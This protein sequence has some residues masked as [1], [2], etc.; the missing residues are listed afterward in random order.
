MKLLHLSDLHLGRLLYRYPLHEQQAEVLERLRQAVVSEKPDAVLIAGDVYDRGIPP[1]YATQLLDGFL[2]GL[3]KTETPVF[4]I[5]GNHDSAERL[6]FLAEPLR[7][8]GLYISPCYRG[9]V[10]PVT[11]E[12][13][14]GPVDIWLLPFLRPA[15]VRPFHPDEEI[16]TTDDAVACAI[17]HMEIDPARRNVLVAHQFVAGG[18]IS[19]SEEACELLGTQDIAVGGS[20]LVSAAH[21][22]PFDYVAL[23]HLHRAQNVGSERIRYC[24]TPMKYSFSELQNGKSITVAELSGQGDVTLRTLPLQDPRGMQEVRGPFA[25]VTDD[26]ALRLHDRDA[27]THVIL[28]DD[29]PVPDVMNRLR[30]SYPNITHLTWD[31]TRT[32]RTEDFAVPASDRKQTPLDLFSEFFERSNGTVM[33]AEQMQYVDGLIRSIWEEDA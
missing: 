15:T 26:E 7:K 9:Q 24:G 10:K 22:A 3:L 23:G 20:D 19:G 6:A 17:R 27:F 31:N 14:D 13:P 12:D 8:S 18:R 29:L 2:A 21:F 16:A 11:L 33:S 1:V 4:L 25:E 32:R 5:S 28:T 30:Q